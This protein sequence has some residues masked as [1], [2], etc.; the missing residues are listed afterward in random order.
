MSEPASMSGAVASIANK[1]SVTGGATAAL[2][3]LT[4][5][6]WLAFGGFIVAVVGLVIQ[7]IATSRKEAREAR[8]EQ[9]RQAEHD[10]E[11]ALNRLR[12][13]E[14]EKEFKDAS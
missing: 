1:V 13:R 11:M 10:A 4:T 7:V 2:G 14:F 6:E 12:M 3:G 5:T 8:D 9:R